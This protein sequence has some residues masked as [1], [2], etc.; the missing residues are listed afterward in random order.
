MASLAHRIL[1]THLYSLHRSRAA[2]LVMAS[3]GL[4]KNMA[5]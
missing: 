4:K 5:S 1:A 2:L 3:K